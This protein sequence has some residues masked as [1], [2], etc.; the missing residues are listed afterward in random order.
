M[1]ES[2]KEQTQQS[3]TNPWAAAIPGLQSLIQKYQGVGTDVTGAQT[4]ALDNLSSAVGS[5][6]NFGEA[7]AGAVNN[8]FNTDNS[9][10]IGM[11]T[12]AF[13]DLQKNLGATASGANLDPYKTPGFADAIRTAINDT[14]NQVKSVYAGSGRDPSGAGSFAQSLGRGIT[15]GISPTIAAQSNTNI[16]NMNDAN[17]TL[18]SGANSTAGGINQLTQQQL[19]NGILG[20]TAGQALPGLAL[21]PGLAQYGIAN[22]QY[23]QPYQNLAALLGPLTQLG[24]MGQQS[25]GQSNTTSTPSLLDSIGTGFSTGGKGLSALGSLFALSDERAKENIEPIGVLFDGQPVHSYN[26]KGDD[27][28]QIGLLAQE[29]ERLNPDA[30]AVVEFDGLKHVHYGRATAR[31]RAMAP[32]RYGLLSEAA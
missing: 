12:G 10:G 8:L 9:A 27:K 29:T 22:Q 11:L 5:L 26:Y 1:T 4:G 14:T 18:F 13:G 24:S 28:P 21:A 2:S 25:N 15:A 32:G 31:A 16:N 17:K 30:H 3:Q 19:Q 6:P 23:Q 7:G 20:M